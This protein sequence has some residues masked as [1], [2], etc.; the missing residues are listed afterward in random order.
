LLAMGSFYKSCTETDFATLHYVT[1]M[2]PFG[3]FLTDVMSFDSKQFTNNS[4]I[5]KFE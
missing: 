5:E 4:I 3:V 1:F 2:E